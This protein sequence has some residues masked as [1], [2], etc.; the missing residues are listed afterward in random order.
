MGGRRM[1][2][3][4]LDAFL[5]AVPMGMSSLAEVMADLAESREMCQR[6]PQP[7][8]SSVAVDNPKRHRQG[9]HRNY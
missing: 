1:S 4:G 9:S 6:Q 7:D 5:H 8:Q 3:L 2:D